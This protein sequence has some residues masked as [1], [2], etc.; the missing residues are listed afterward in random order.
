[1][2]YCSVLKSKH[3]QG[4]SRHSCH[5]DKS[6]SP[7]ERTFGQCR[8]YEYTAL[9]APENKSLEIKTPRPRRVLRDSTLAAWY[10]SPYAPRTG[11]AYDSHHRTAGI[12]GRTRRG[13]SGVAARGARAA[14]GAAGYR[15]AARGTTRTA[16]VTLSR[17]YIHRNMARRTRIEY[18][19]THMMSEAQP[20]LSPTA[21]SLMVNSPWRSN[22]LGPPPSHSQPATK[23]MDRSLG[24]T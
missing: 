14:A 19:A 23:R 6:G 4:H 15:M 2:T 12:A 20:R 3:S 9:R 16:T 21:C 10:R 1:V 22:A 5:P 24:Q 11:G 13:G 8:V 17:N 18:S 7:R